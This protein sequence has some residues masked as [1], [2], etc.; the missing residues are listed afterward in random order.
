MRNE[1][2]GVI[3]HTELG[4]SFPA[5]LEADVAAFSVKEENHLS[6]FWFELQ[7]DSCEDFMGKFYFLAFC[8]ILFCFCLEFF[9]VFACLVGF[10]CP[11]V[12]WKRKFSKA[13]LFFSDGLIDV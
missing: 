10:F 12:K 5:R 3:T 4:L 9:S 11:G 2:G 8:R 6:S 13:D 1:P 7:D